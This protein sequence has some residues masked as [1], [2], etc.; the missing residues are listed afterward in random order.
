MSF[1]GELFVH[2]FLYV[3]SWGRRDLLNMKISGE[4]LV[5]LIFICRALCEDV[6]CLI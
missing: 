5:H 3:G 2:L 6:S 4:L 1:S